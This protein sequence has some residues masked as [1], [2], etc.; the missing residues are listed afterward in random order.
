MFGGNK[1]LRCVSQTV[2]K[3]VLLQSIMGLVESWNIGYL[4]FRMLIVRIFRMFRNKFPQLQLLLMQTFWRKIFWKKYK[5]EYFW[6]HQGGDIL[7]ATTR[8]EWLMITMMYFKYET[9]QSSTIT[10]IVIVICCCECIYLVKYNSYQCN[11]YQ[12]YFNQGLMVA[13]WLNWFLDCT[14][15]ISRNSNPQHFFKSVRISILLS[16]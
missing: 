15:L 12:F 13:S 9:I 10:Y 11:V 6:G 4:G 2:V 14:L 7:Q 3:R 16:A 8:Y 1:T 5:N